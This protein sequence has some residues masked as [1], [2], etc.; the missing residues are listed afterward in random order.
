MTELLNQTFN[1][2]IT[3]KVGANGALMVQVEELEPMTPEAFISWLHSAAK[4]PEPTI[5]PASRASV[6]VWRDTK[7]S[8]QPKEKLEKM[9]E[10]NRQWKKFKRKFP[11]KSN[12]ELN[13]MTQSWLDTKAEFLAS[14]ADSVALEILN[15]GF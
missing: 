15:G 4:S 1:L 12:E 3:P 7:E 11:H 9:N 6:A 8:P 10:F 5:R 14:F 2:N 13:K